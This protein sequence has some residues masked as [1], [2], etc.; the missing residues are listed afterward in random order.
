[1]NEND[2]GFLNSVDD[3]RAP[4]LDIVRAIY[5]ANRL[6]CECARQVLKDSLV[7]IQDTFN[8]PAGLNPEH[9]NLD[10]SPRVD[11]PWAWDYEGATAGARIWLPAPVDATFWL[12]IDFRDPKNKI[13]AALEF[14]NR[15]R[16]ARWREQFV[17]ASAFT[18]ATWGGYALVMA[19][20][21]P[22]RDFAKLDDAL[23]K[24]LQAYLTEVHRAR[25]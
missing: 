10:I 22:L 17:E 24:L 11:T 12:F 25:G 13:V 8:I 5:R 7:N 4:F 15:K 1:M 19:W 2:I 18:E 20:D 21:C 6:M 3:P 16:R 14:G 9:V 23:T